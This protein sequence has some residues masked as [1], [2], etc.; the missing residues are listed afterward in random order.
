MI[1][2]QQERVDTELEKTFEDR[3]THLAQ[4]EGI[5]LSEHMRKKTIKK[6]EADWQKTVKSKKN[7]E[8]YNKLAELESEQVTKETKIREQSHQLNIP[9]EKLT[10]SVSK[11]MAAKYE[12]SL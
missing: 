3:K 10:S 4:Q 9:G 2:Y 11:N 1:Q 12:Q 8:Y 6:D 5:N 7:E